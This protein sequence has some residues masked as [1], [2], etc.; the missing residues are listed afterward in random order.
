LLFSLSLSLSR[1]PY[2]SDNN[3][4]KKGLVRHPASD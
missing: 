1:S 4:I 3:T 2:S